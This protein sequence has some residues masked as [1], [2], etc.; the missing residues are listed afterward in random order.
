MIH[1]QTCSWWRHSKYSWY[2]DH[3]HPNWM[4]RCFKHCKKIVNFCP[5][6]HTRVI[7][8]M[9][10]I[11]GRWMEC[12]IAHNLPFAI[13]STLPFCP[14][15]QMVNLGPN[16]VLSNYNFLIGLQIKSAP[17]TIMGIVRVKLSI[18]TWHHYILTEQELI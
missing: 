1:L 9:Q 10:C 5:P 7:L 16:C 12:R 18:L 11:G 13:L 4:L 6:K 2:G 17:Q 15:M 3:H 8:P 14:L